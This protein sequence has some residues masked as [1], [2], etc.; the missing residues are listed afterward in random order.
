MFLYH[1]GYVMETYH[2]YHTYSDRPENV[3]R[4]ETP[5]IAVYDQSTL[6]ATYPAI[7]WDNVR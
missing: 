4:D 5:Q 6:F 1:L 2:M 7:F 3:D